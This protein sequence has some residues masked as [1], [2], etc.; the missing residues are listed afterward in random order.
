MSIKVETAKAKHAQGIPLEKDEE[1][2]LGQLD[3][4]DL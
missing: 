4:K 3:A 2:I 1:E